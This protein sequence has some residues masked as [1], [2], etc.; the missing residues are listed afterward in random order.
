MVAGCGWMGGRW[1]G[2]EWVL[3]VGSEQPSTSTSCF[4]GGPTSADDG[5]LSCAMAEWVTGKSL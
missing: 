5:G 1:C 2:V 3:A 4:S